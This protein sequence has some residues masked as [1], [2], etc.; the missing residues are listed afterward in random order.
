MITLVKHEWHQVDSQFA[1]ELDKDKLTEI[2]PELDDGDIDA[3]LKEIESGEV[4][5][6]QLIADAE[7]SGVDFEWERQYDDWWTDRKGGYEITYELGDDSSWHTPPSPPL[8]TKK[9][10]QCRWAGGPHETRTIYFDKNGVELSDDCD[11]YDRTAD[12]CPMCD[13]ALANINPSHQCTSCN[14]AGPYLDVDSVWNKDSDEQHREEGDYC[15]ECGSQVIE[16][17]AGD[18]E[19]LAGDGLPELPELPDEPSRDVLEE[20]LDELKKELD[21]VNPPKKSSKKTKGKR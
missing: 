9:C 5:V 1:V 6:D 2:Y 20:A 7:E 17:K 16:T 18:G 14:W 21:L 12:V 11:H 10:T 3:K 15:P 4:S 8:P 19:V 13:G